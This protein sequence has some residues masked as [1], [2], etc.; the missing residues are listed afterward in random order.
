MRHHQMLRLGREAIQGAWN[1]DPK[2][3]VTVIVV[4]GKHELKVQEDSQ[5]IPLDSLDLPPDLEDMKPIDRRIFEVLG[6]DPM[7][8]EKIAHEARYTPGNHVYESLKRLQ[9][10]GHAIHLP[11]GYARSRKQPETS[12]VQSP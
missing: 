11:K 2:K 4:C 6:S 7:T 9:D 5:E 10:A 3:P 12:S 8:M 1:C